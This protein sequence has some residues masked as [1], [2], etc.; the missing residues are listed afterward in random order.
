MNK[1]KNEISALKDKCKE[2]L[3]YWFDPGNRDSWF[4]KSEEF[5]SEIRDRFYDLWKM[6]AEGLLWPWRETLHGRLAEI[7]VIDQFSRNLFRD[8]PYAFSQDKMALVLSQEAIKHPDFTGMSQEERNF[9]LLPLMHS[10]S[11]RIH[12]QSVE[13]FEKW[14]SEETL[15]YEYLHKE[16]LDRFGRYPY[17]NE[18]LGRESTL[19][20]IEFLKQPGS[21]F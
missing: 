13:L 18:A 14:A 4:K 12:E 11:A 6:G 2:V 16:I 20:E 19:E 15:K 8:S 9:L 3:D 5:D 7:I 17:R 10:E 21:S 1:A